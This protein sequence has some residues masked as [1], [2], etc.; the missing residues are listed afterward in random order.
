MG[1]HELAAHDQRS[2]SHRG[3]LTQRGSREDDAVGPQ[4]GTRIELHCIETHHPIMEQVSLDHT[5]AVDRRIVAEADEVGLRQP[6]ALA[7][8]SVADLRAH[9][10][11]VPHDRR[12]AHGV[13]GEPG[14]GH[15]FDEA[16]GDLVAPDE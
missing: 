1:R 10:P 4:S 8:H 5:A 7:P 14:S 13:P 2:R 6:V 3:V 12:R 9:R 11:Q 16:V 15:E